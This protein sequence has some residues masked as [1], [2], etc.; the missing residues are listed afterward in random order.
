MQS[1]AFFNNKGGVGKTTLAFHISWMLHELGKRV[2]S[3]DLDPQANL[4][5]MFMFDS[6]LE[7]LIEKRKSLY[8]SLEPL[9]KGLGDIKPAEVVEK[10]WESGPGLLPGDLKLSKMEADFSS[11]WPQCLDREERAFRLTAAFSR[12]IKM[13]GEEM[14]A[15][16]VIIDMGPNLGAINRAALIS[17]DYVIFPLGP[18]LFSW[19]G[20]KNTGEVLTQWRRDWQERKEKKPAGLDFPLP[21]GK[22]IPLGYI[23][24]RHSMRYDRPV[25]AYQNWI[26]KMPSAYKNY[27]LNEE[28]REKDKKEDKKEDIGS[29]QGSNQ[30]SN[31]EEDKDKKEDKKENIGSN[32]RSNREEDKD[33]KEDRE[34]DKDT[35]SDEDYMLAHIKDYRSL[36][37]MAQEKRKPVFLLKP[38]DGAIGSHFQAALACREHF[39]ELTKKI[40]SKT[41]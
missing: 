9:N 5:G 39:E 37:P 23:M 34:K 30:R 15:D 8:Y 36:M 2:L 21:E 29:N 38:G 26:D 25:K 18:D 6:D 22:M 35:A 40:L 28:D 20:L 7:E 4:T 12:L 33:K 16:W 3:V 41:N 13:A 24:M 14:E 17:A 11:A 10:E 27:V 19:Q 32:Q 1:L 31:R